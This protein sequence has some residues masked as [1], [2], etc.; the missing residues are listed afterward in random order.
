M[1][2]FTHLTRQA[3]SIIIPDGCNHFPG[4]DHHLD[5]KKFWLCL[6]SGVPLL[7]PEES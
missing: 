4:S 6:E 1:K 5:T 7:S 3:L 2:L